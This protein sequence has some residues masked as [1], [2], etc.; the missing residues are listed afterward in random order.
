M[1][2]ATLRPSAAAG[3]RS[4]RPHLYYD[5]PPLRE[6][7]SRFVGQVFASRFRHQRGVSHRIAAVGA[8]AIPDQIKLNGPAGRGRTGS[9]ALSRWRH[10]FESRWGCHSLDPVGAGISQSWQRFPGGRR[11]PCGCPP[12]A[13]APSSGASVSVT[14]VPRLC[15]GEGRTP[16]P[17]P[18][19]LGRTLS[20]H[21]LVRPT[22]GR[23]GQFVRKVR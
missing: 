12:D 3:P 18:T 15:P 13:P 1:S 10:G 21:L 4:D 16:S 22:C 5:L 11:R 6:D 17:R 14:L 19:I 2:G 20:R 8:E 23:P 7:S 9:S